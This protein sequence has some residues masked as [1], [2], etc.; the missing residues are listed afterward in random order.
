MNTNITVPSSTTPA[1]YAQGVTHPDQFYVLAALQGDQSAYAHLMRRYQNMVYCLVLRSL[2]NTDEAQ[3]ATQDTFIKAFKYL[4]N[5][6]G[7][8][9]FSSWLYRVAQTTVCD[10]HR[11]KH[12]AKRSATLVSDTVLEVLPANT[13]TA[14]DNF[15][16]SERNKAIQQAMRK[17]LTED[18]TILTMFYFE[19]LSLND[20]CALKNMEM[21]N[22]KSRL[23]RARQRLGVVLGP[24]V[25]E[26]V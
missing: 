2:R 14:Y 24:S 5:W 25:L 11:R 21:S 3:E 18:R 26:A 17:L 22:A 7:E 10:Y 13:A 19:N 9:K 20:I 8:C 15:V 4:A 16:T 23:C 1:L 12:A 6:R